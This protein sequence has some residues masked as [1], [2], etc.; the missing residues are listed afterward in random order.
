MKKKLKRPRKKVKDQQKK[1]TKKY[2]FV[3]HEVATAYLKFFI[4]L[5]GVHWCAEHECWHL[6]STTG[7]SAN[8]IDSHK[9]AR[10][11]NKLIRTIPPQLW[12]SSNSKTA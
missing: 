9:I 10:D 5:R 2:R 1:C 8:S 12:K 4:H 11:Q 7:Q 6:T 3:S